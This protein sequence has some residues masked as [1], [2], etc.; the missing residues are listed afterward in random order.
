MIGCG[1]VDGAAAAL[2]KIEAGASLVQLYT[3]LIYR[4]PWL[5]EEILTGLA[6]TMKER[7]IRRLA[8]IVGGGAREWAA[9][10]D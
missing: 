8:E 10:K 9:A 6:R 4:G 1:G 7:R 5:I 3:A 2:A